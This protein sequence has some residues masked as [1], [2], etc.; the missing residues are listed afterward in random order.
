MDM[1]K[2]V[3]DLINGGENSFVEFKRELITPAHF[4]EE[5]VAFLN[6]KGGVIILGVSDKGEIIGIEKKSIKKVEEWVINVCRN[7]IIPPVIPIYETVKIEDKI[8]VKISVVEGIEKPY[9]TSRGKYFIRVGSTKR[10]SSK[11][12]LLRL[13]QNTVIY[14]IDD[15]PVAGSSVNDINTEKISA[16]FK[17]NYEIEWNELDDGERKKLLL[18]SCILSEYDN[19]VFATISGLIFFAKKGDMPL[20]PSERYL[21]N[22]G[23][24]FVSYRD[25]EMDEIL[26]RYLCFDPSPEIVDTIVQ[27]IKINWKVPSRI[28]G[29][30]RK[31]IQFPNKIFRELVVNAIVHR[32][33][34]ISANIEIKMFPFKIE[35]ISPGRLVNTVTIDKMKAGISISRNPIVLKFMEN[36]RY[37]DHLGRGIPMIVR[38]IKKMPGFSVDFDEG[39]DRFC[40]TLHMP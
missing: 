7:N 15:R 32:D 27:K 11:E 20:N 21:S 28:E 10:L 34:S 36:Y 40:V 30:R 3:L 25:E 37:A 33:Y 19:K 12:E 5:V 17:E 8:L 23:V 29:L 1:V 6:V 35:I 13:F 31:E 39:D 18:N 16:Y 4:A 38:E 9:Q 24:Q 14:H 2:D 26:D 22:T